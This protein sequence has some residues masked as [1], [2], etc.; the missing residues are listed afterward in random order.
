MM[1]YPAIDLKDGCCVRLIE[2]RADQETV[3]SSDP[4]Q[5]ALDFRAAGARY[6]HIVDLDGAF[7]GRPVN[8]DAIRAI[9]AAV[10]IPIQVGGG[11]RTE[12]DVEYILNLGA[13]RVI[14]GT[15]AVSSP[16]FVQRLLER[17]GVERIV[18]G[19]DARD[20]KVAVQGWVEV[21][22]LDAVRFGREMYDLGIR[23][24]VYTDI[25]RDGRLQGPNLEA[26]NTMLQ[27]TGLNII[28]SGGVSSPENIKALKALKLPGMDGAIVGKALYDGKMNLGQAL[29]AADE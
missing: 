23:T 17:F 16:E 14:I 20:G 25:S 22:D 29:A 9:A 28:A 4:R 13:A 1:I 7:G 2:G 3:Y 21:S 19:V 10:D 27:Q 24:A 6:L 12:E 26:I 18:L 15:K 5:V 11:L 8:R